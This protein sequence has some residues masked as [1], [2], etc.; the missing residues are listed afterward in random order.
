[1]GWK[2]VLAQLNIFILYLWIFKDVLKKVDVLVVVE[3]RP[4]SEDVALLDTA[5]DVKKQV[6]FCCF[7]VQH[8]L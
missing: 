2:Q 8:Y 5:N 7:F 1:M 6:L 4:N 3:N